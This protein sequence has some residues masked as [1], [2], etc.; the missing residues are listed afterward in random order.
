MDRLRTC[1]RLAFVVVCTWATVACATRLPDPRPVHGSGSDAVEVASAEVAEPGLRAAPARYEARDLGIFGS[2]S[3]GG[4]CLPCEQGQSSWHVRGVFGW[5]FYSGDDD[6]ADDAYF[7]ADLGY[8]SCNGCWGLDLFFRT[9]SAELTRAVPGAALVRQDGDFSHLGV[10]LTY[11]GSFSSTFFGWL[12]V[13]PEFWWTDGY[14][15][16]EDGFGFFVEAGLGVNLSRNV[17]LRGGVN[18]HGFDTDVVRL[19]PADDDNS[20]FL[21]VIAPVVEL[22]FSF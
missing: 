7:G 15:R 2:A 22:E 21:L 12:G 5:A 16:D 18:L 4:G 14:T 10:K 20:R 6:P 17:R 9:H 8:T 11:Q 1:M 13:G 3:G 19:D